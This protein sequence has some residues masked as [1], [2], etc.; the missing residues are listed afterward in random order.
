MQI[1]Q[2]SKNIY[3]VKETIL[4]NTMLVQQTRRKINSKKKWGMCTEEDERVL[5]EQLGMF[6]DKT[7]DV[8]T[9]MIKRYC[10]S[11]GNEHT[12]KRQKIIELDGR[13]TKYIEQYPEN[14][15][16]KVK[17][18]FLYGNYCRACHNKASGDY[19]DLTEYSLYDLL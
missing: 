7:Y 18:Y 17:R 5:N 12:T 10:C 16:E 4:D 11:C 6:R 13:I 3:R 19:K 9:N 2:V 8:D 14:S 15:F 1:E